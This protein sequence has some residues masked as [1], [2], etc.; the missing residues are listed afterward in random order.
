MCQS[1]VDVD[2]Q[3]ENYRAIL[4]SL[5]EPAEIERINQL[6]AK[7]YADRVRLHRNKDE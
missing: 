3:V 2:K 6:I 5:A 7:L 1:C 4:H